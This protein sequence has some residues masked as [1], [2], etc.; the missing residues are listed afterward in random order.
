MCAS[1]AS[2]V[3]QWPWWTV[4]LCRAIHATVMQASLCPPPPRW[5]RWGWG[6]L[7]VSGTRRTGRHWWSR[8]ERQHIW[9]TLNKQ[10][11]VT[12]SC[13]ALWNQTH[14]HNPALLSLPRGSNLYL[15]AAEKHI[16]LFSGCVC[17]PVG[18]KRMT[19]RTL[20]EPQSCRRGTV[21]WGGIHGMSK[22][23]WNTAGFIGYLRI[24]AAAQPVLIN[25][26][27]RG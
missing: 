11:S 19:T 16:C 24:P 18:S 21:H 2:C 25:N 4:S 12:G 10:L 9:T 17:A 5:L 1:I 7:S 20:C 27:P 8:P 22:L 6:P 15:F 26:S 23:S 14:I 13:A 3:L